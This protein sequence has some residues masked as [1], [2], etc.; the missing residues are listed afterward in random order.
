MTLTTARRFL[1][2]GLGLFVIG[3]LVIAWVNHQHAGAD[4]PVSAELTVF[5]AFIAAGT[6]LAVAWVGWS[7]L[8]LGAASQAIAQWRVTADAWQAYVAA[9]RMRETMPGAL[10]G[11]VPLDL[12][13]PPDGIDVLALRRGFRVGDSF[14]EMGT[15]SADV[16][17][18]RVVDAPAAM[19]EFNVVYA[20]GKY[21]SVSRAVRIPLAADA[22]A[23]AHQVEG[24]WV[25]REPMLSMTREVLQV[26]ERAGWWMVAG[27]FGA[28]AGALVLFAVINPPGWAAIVPVSALGVLLLGIMRAVRARNVRRRRFG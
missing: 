19:F 3:A 17:D 13:V 14:H 6:S 1:Q 28:F 24:F 27:G 20:A 26:R 2:F 21:S 23:A 18:M 7:T 5:G 15:L 4:L 16:F 9:C 25:A 12:P 11:A 8:R 22:Q 10:R